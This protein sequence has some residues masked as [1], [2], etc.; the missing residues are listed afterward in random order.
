MKI[1][2][3]SGFKCEVDTNKLS[4][5]RFVKL[6]RRVASNDESEQF[7]ATVDL[8]PF[9]LGEKGEERLM[10]HIADANGYVSTERM[11]EEGEEIFSLLQSENNEVKN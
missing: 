8:I 2:T 4:D 11:M 10:D 7:A 3:K 1:T 5:Y 9:L 6:I